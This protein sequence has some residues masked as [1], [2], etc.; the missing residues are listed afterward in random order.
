MEYVSEAG[1]EPMRAEPSCLGI[2]RLDRSAIPPLM[3]LLL[4]L[5]LLLVSQ[6]LS[7]GKII[8]R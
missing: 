8:E 1:F 2:R 7:P 6:I 3:L 4:A 5:L